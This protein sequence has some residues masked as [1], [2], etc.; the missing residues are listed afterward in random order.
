MLI[1]YTITLVNITL[2]AMSS[3]ALLCILSLFEYFK[4]NPASENVGN[5][6]LEKNLDNV[7]ND[8]EFLL[9]E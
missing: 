3:Y 2:I 7:E 5:K 1:N 6:K 8:V 9:Q 4:K